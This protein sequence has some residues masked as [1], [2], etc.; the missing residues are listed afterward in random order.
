[1]EDESSSPERNTPPS[2]PGRSHPSPGPTPA[3]GT[4]QSR[5]C[6]PGFRPVRE[7]GKKNTPMSLVCAKAEEAELG[8]DQVTYVVRVQLAVSGQAVEKSLDVRPEDA[9]T[10][11]IVDLVQV[12]S[13]AVPEV[14]G[15][16]HHL[17]KRKGDTTLLPQQEAAF[18]LTSPTCS[19]G[20]ETASIQPNKNNC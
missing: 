19:G 15:D 10:S 2:P 14:E 16:L 11:R 20:A 9:V 3:S 18:Q 17:V 7:K 8:E 12:F 1:M 13:Q 5:L 4:P 6:P